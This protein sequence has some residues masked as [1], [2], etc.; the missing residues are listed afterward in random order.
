M[1]KKLCLQVKDAGLGLKDDPY[2]CR[3]PFG[4]AGLHQCW[5]CEKKWRKS[6]GQRKRK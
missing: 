2:K 3:K 5:C 1:S 6:D 4:H